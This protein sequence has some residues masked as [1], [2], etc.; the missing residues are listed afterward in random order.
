MRIVLA[1][2]SPRRR[3]LLADAGYEF[4][5]CVSQLDES[6][7]SAQGLSAG[8]YAELLALAKARAVAGKFP[9]AVVLGADT[10]VDFAG[11]IIGK[12]EDASEA[13]QI[14]RKL[15]SR[16]HK[17]ITGVALVRQVDDLEIVDSD[18]TTVFPRKLSAE[19]ID[20]HV[21]SDAWRGKAGAY[22]IQESGDEFVEKVDGSISNVVGLPM[23]LLKK[24]LAS[25]ETTA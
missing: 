20:A 11:E 13:E 15:F 4:E 22:A 2:A 3:Q 10:V 24:M 21:A 8:E 7:Y 14:T 23:E 9:N 19:Q 12:A 5:V 18:S 16:P 17:V 6:S 1:S 25:I